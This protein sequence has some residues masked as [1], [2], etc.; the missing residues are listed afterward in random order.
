MF[1]GDGSGEASDEYEDD[2]PKKK[3][4]EEKLQSICVCK[5]FLSQTMPLPFICESEYQ[6]VSQ[7]TDIPEL[8]PLGTIIFCISKRSQI[9]QNKENNQNEPLIVAWSNMKFTTDTEFSVIIPNF[10][11]NGYRFNQ[12]EPTFYPM[13][14]PTVKAMENLSLFRHDFQNGRAVFHYVGQGFP[15]ITSEGIYSHPE[16]GRTTLLTT[17]QSLFTNIRTPSLFVFDCENAGIV[18]NSFK[19]TED[20]LT[21]G[22]QTAANRFPIAS[23][24][25]IEKED[26]SDWFCL[27]ATSPGERLPIDPI[28]P[29]DFLST[30][31]L[32]PISI[33]IL[34]HILKHYKTSFKTSPLD[35]INSII[36]DSKKEGIDHLTEILISVTE[37]IAADYLT[38][39]LFMLFFR[40]E[41]FVRT[42]FRRFVL[43][44]FLLHQYSVHP[45]SHPYLPPMWNHSSWVQWE[46]ALDMWISQKTL[47]SPFSS[48]FF[49]HSMAVT[50]TS[51]VLQGKASTTKKSLLTCASC[52]PSDDP[53]GKL[54]LVPLAIYAADSQLNRSN[55][56][57]TINFTTFMEILLEMPNRIEKALKDKQQTTTLILDFH[58]LCYIIVSALHTDLNTLV[59]FPKNVNIEPLISLTMNP[60]IPASTRTLATAILTI[61][62]KP[63]KSLREPFTS[64]SFYEK[65]QNVLCVSDSSLTLWYLL[66]MKRAHGFLSVCSEIDNTS[67]ELCVNLLLFHNTPEVRAAAISA[68]SLFCIDQE[69]TARIMFSLIFSLFDCSYIVRNQVLLLVIRCLSSHLPVNASQFEQSIQ[70]TSFNDIMMQLMSTKTHFSKYSADFQAF[71]QETKTAVKEGDLI[72][73]LCFIISYLL[74]DPNKIVVDNA[75]K[76]K[77]LFIAKNEKSAIAIPLEMQ[78]GKTDEFLIASTENSTSETE[79]ASDSDALFKAATDQLVR[80]GMWQPIELH[81]A[82]PTLYPAVKLPSQIPYPNA[83]VTT[84]HSTLQGTFPLR[85]TYMGDELI[86][87]TNNKNIYF[88]NQDLQPRQKIKLS[89]AETCDIR[90]MNDNLIVSTADGCV[91]IWHE[92]RPTI[93]F[94]AGAAYQSQSLIQLAA[95]SPVNPALI[96]TARNASPVALWDISV[97]RMLGEW[98]SISSPASA[99]QMDQEQQYV[100]YL[101]CA[102]GSIA[103]MDFRVDMMLQPTKI[104]AANGSDRILRIGSFLDDSYSIYA[105]T[106]GGRIIKWDTRTE[107]LQAIISNR[108]QLASFSIHQPSNTFF[109]S[110]TNGQPWISSKN[111]DILVKIQNV[112]PQGSIIAT[113]KTH[114]VATL[115]C[116][117]G[118]M[119]AYQMVLNSQ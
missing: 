65:L 5:D 116:S 109:T 21:E 101:G 59:G 110:P 107:K 57:S 71:I 13:I 94:R 108:G 17:F 43:A 117:N 16:N 81:P 31:L 104:I 76:A 97:Q 83:A 88:L 58:A 118:E 56:T 66:L 72:K 79:F 15:P 61:L 36:K 84:A 105:G 27:C 93:S 9:V 6:N 62:Q 32:T 29:K 98:S 106:A 52:I 100:G 77:E 92:Q 63:M 30:A 33:A 99:L 11:K 24:Y 7:N 75:Q 91:H 45:I 23:K 19:A 89:A 112:P 69:Q 73:M 95:P 2:I 42:L 44:Q 12:K 40:R 50:F 64:P 111:G 114:A 28:L 90:S 22:S 85:A 47:P 4:I 96:S 54:A 20:N 82:P 55:I 51:A 67:L 46:T 74:F 38:P 78:E 48:A 1:F 87:A 102:N 41:P 49:F 3:T 115:I 53:F 10:F 18:I 35:Y 25:L 26:W 80:S 113:H 14:D 68:L 86:V 119:F 8:E 60:L 39:R 70:A 34:C 103:Q 37:C